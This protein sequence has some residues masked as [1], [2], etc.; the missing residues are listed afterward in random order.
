MQ[1]VIHKSLVERHRILSE[2]INDPPEGGVQLGE[3]SS[4]GRIFPLVPYRRFLNGMTV[5]KVSR[6]EED[7]QEAF[8]NALKGQVSKQMATSNCRCRCAGGCVWNL[9]S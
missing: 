1:S 2:M 4:V 6:S 5:S 9:G 8:E 7:I 3:S